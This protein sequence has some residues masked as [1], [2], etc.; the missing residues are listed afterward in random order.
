MCKEKERPHA[1]QV[2]LSADERA[3]LEKVAAELGLS[4]A[5]AVRMLIRI[6]AGEVRL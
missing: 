3:M 2:W 1:F 5:A 6:R 4:Q